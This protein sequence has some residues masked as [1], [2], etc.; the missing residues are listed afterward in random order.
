M[1][2]KE[3]ETEGGGGDLRM[4]NLEKITR[5]CEEWKVDS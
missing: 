3:R 5:L 4:L 1:A 2:G